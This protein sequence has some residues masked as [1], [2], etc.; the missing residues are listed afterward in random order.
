MSEKNSYRKFRSNIL[1]ANDRINRV[2]NIYLDGMFDVNCCINGNEFWMEI[3]TP[4]EP[5]RKATPLFGS[6]HKFSID[7][8]NWAISQCNAG[9][10]CYAYIETNLRAMLIDLNDIDI[11]LINTFTVDEFIELAIWVCPR[12]VRKKYWDSFR[13]AIA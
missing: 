11:S 8:I 13:E 5:F 10:R 4:D 6:N 9:G 2:E 7:Q 3:K 12:P 1:R